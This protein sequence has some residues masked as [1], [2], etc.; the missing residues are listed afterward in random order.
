VDQYYWPLTTEK[1]VTAWIPLHAVPLENGPL[2][3]SVGSQRIKIGRDLEI[4]DES[5]KKIQE[6]LKLTN[7]PIDETPF[8]LGEVSFHLGFTFHRAGPN[9]LSKAREVM[10]IIFMDKD[11]RLAEPKN[12][13]QKNDWDNWCPGAKLGEIIDSPLNPIIYSRN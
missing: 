7:L 11:M 13:N 1:T 6:Q 4:S 5:E 10:T 12:Q 3:F 9:K 2:S 8:D